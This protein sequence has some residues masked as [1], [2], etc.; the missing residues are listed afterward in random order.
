METTAPAAVPVSVSTP[1]EP[2]RE[3]WALPPT[4][5]MRLPGSVPARDAE[6]ATHAEP[7]PSA[8]PALVAEPAPSADPDPLA[9]SRAVEGPDGE[10]PPRVRAEAGAADAIAEV[11][12]HAEALASPA[13]DAVDAD[14]TADDVAAADAAPMTE[15]GSGRSEAAD[16]TAP[17]EAVGEP[18]QVGGLDEVTVDGESSPAA[19]AEGSPSPVPEPASPPQDAGGVPVWEAALP[20]ANASESV[21]VAERGESEPGDVVAAGVPVKKPGHQVKPGR[22]A[23]SR[24]SRSRRPGRRGVEVG[25]VASAVSSADRFAGEP[26]AAPE[27]GGVEAGGGALDLPSVARDRDENTEREVLAEATPA[28]PDPCDHEGD[29]RP[30]VGDLV[31]GESEVE[32]SVVEDSAVE[33]SVVDDTGERDCA[34]EVP[35]E[36]RVADP[37]AA[38]PGE[39]AQVAPTPIEEPGGRPEGEGVAAPPVEAHSHAWQPPAAAWPPPEEPHPWLVPEPA[40]AP[41]VADLRAAS[42]PAQPAE[43]HPWLAAQHAPVPAPSPGRDEPGDWIDQPQRTPDGHPASAIGGGSPFPQGRHYGVDGRVAPATPGD[44]PYAGQVIWE[45]ER[46]LPYADLRLPADRRDPWA[47]SPLRGSERF[48]V[49]AAHWTALISTWVGPALILLT[50]GEN[51]LRIREHARRSLNFEITMALLLLGASL[52]TL[53]GFVP[54]VLAVG[55]VVGLW[56]VARVVGAVRAARGRVVRYPGSIPFIRG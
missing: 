45:H 28:E 32:D 55:G 20:A 11:P 31:V 39:A 22:R 46:A 7:A 9:T 14:S 21:V 34:G 24:R 47:G 6:P 16:T 36:D 54:G 17:I 41:R 19:D 12:D 29:T 4:L 26:A 37:L 35:C 25:D 38:V 10:P 2:V 49:P 18:T 44:A 40:P 42:W 23:R 8:E 27:G 52:I 48:A 3:P 51:N 30:V 5:R 1:P 43:P 53:T 33:E 56:F 50:A 13:S 15:T